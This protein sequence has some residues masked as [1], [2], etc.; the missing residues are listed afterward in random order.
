MR[1]NSTSL[2]PTPPVAPPCRGAKAV[3]AVITVLLGAAAY[4]RYYQPSFR[5]GLDIDELITLQNYT[6]AGVNGDGSRHRLERLGDVERLGTPSA[7]RLLIG[8]YCSLGRWAEPNNHVAYSLLSDVAL[9]L[10]GPK[11]VAFRLPALIAAAAFALAV[12]AI[13]WRCRWYATALPTALIAFYHPYVVVF[14]QSARGYTLMNLLVAASLVAA[15][16]ALAAPASIAAGA[17]LDP[18]A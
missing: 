3:M 16:R 12:A 11:V 13:C 9:A 14:S 7:M 10:T 18:P 15:E 6:W 1:P 8:T 17:G 2:R 4:D 5:R